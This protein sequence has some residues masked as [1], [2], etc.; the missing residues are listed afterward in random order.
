[1]SDADPT[2][3]RGP[4]ATKELGMSTAFAHVRP[5]YKYKA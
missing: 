1:M 5:G 4:A 2:M 3:A